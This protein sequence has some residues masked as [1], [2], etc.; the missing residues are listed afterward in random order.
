[1]ADYTAEPSHAMLL[2]LLHPPLQPMNAAAVRAETVSG[3]V[4][5]S[6]A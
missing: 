4:T 5:P 2:P 1:M 3:A 6:S